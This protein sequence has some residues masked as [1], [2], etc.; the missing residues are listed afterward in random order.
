[1]LLLLITKWLAKAIDYLMRIKS[2]QEKRKKTTTR[3][4]KEEDEMN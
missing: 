1:L 4:K 3:T 2:K